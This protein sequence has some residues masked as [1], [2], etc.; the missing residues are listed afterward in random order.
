MKKN[1]VIRFP[2]IPWYQKIEKMMKLLVLLLTCS[3]LTLSANTMAQQQ[4]VTLN[5]KNCSVKDLF[6]EIQR[7]TDLFFV[8]NLRNFENVGTIN[9]KAK[10]EEVDKVLARVFE[11]RDVE[12]LFEDNTVVV[13]PMPLQQQQVQE[14]KVTGVV[15][16]E[17]GNVLPGVAIVIKGT[18]MGT[19]TDADGKYSLTLPEGDYT[20]VFS[21]IGM[22]A[23]EEAVGTRS[24]I[25][26]TLVEEVTEMEEVVVTG[27]FTYGVSFHLYGN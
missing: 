16:D 13:R 5:L 23:K 6:Y 4:R 15:K 17:R 9:V 7:Q 1:R 27:I 12:F 19:S 18:T 26:V 21:F 22:M 25:N 24:E 3:C 20:L 2:G 14:R 8:Y 10:N 11:G